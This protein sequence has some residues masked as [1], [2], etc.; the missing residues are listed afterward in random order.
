MQ[1]LKIGL[2][3][4]DS[5]VN[6]SFFESNNPVLSEERIKAAAIGQSTLSDNTTIIA[7]TMTV[8]GAVNKTFVLFGLM[9]LTSFASY[10]MPSMFLLITGAIGG[11]VAVLFASFK[12]KTSAISAPVY[13]L[14]E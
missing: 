1:F 4:G 11:L 3:G 6:K 9:M 13:A 5:M 7:S 12:P 8:A 10:L 2:F 14:F